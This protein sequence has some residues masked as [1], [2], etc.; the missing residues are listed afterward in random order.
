MPE[1]S[2]PPSPQPLPPPHHE[3]EALD[4]PV[5]VPCANAFDDFAF[6]ATDAAGQHRKGANEERQPFLQGHHKAPLKFI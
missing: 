5:G 4:H 2:K 1:K 6:L 3:P